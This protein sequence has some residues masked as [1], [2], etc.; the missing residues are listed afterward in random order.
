MFSRNQF[1]KVGEECNY[2][3]PAVGFRIDN[4][5]SWGFSGINLVV[6]QKEQEG[7]YVTT[8][9]RRRFNYTNPMHTFY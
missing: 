3:I 9:S 4:Y 5:E 1:V 2:F 7:L 8:T 6:S